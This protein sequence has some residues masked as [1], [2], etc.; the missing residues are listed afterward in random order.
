M[1]I[2]LDHQTL[3]PL[4][5]RCKKPKSDLRPVSDT[6][7]PGPSRNV[8]FF[9]VGQLFFLVVFYMWDP[10]PVGRERLNEVYCTFGRDEILPTSWRYIKK[11]NPT[12]KACPKRFSP[13]RSASSAV[14]GG[15]TVASP[16]P[17]A[18]TPYRHHPRSPSRTLPCSQWKLQFKVLWETQL[19]VP[20]YPPF[21]LSLS[22]VLL[23]Q[24]RNTTRPR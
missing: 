17:K 4:F 3:A 9:H 10:P 14:P 5:L 22:Q 11:K 16:A 23:P 6:Q 15:A 18:L 7:L 24:L 21:L 19:Q 12:P 8:T 20:F 2:A 13:R 1:K